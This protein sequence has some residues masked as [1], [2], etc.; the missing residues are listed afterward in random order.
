V[1]FTVVQKI[2]LNLMARTWIIADEEMVHCEATED[3]A[4]AIWGSLG[5]PI[6]VRP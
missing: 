1:W 5:G 2:S 6:E 4:A 3:D